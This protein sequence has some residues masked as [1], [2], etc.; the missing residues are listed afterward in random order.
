M[1][2]TQIQPA[3]LVG[4]RSVYDSVFWLAYAANVALMTANALTFR[5]AE[6]VAF[7]G[8][9]EKTAGAI[10][11]VGVVGALLVRLRLGQAIDRFGTRK[12][13]LLSSLLFILGCGML[14]VWRQLSWEMY[15]ARIAFSAGLAGMFTCSIVHIQNQV[16]P[17][18]RTEVIGTLGSSGFVG[19]IAGTLL[20]DA[21]FTALPEGDT[22]FAALFGG[23][24]GLGMV[25]VAIVTLLTH[26]D[27]HDP[28][29]QMP[30][31]LRLLFRYW[32]GCVVLAAL[33]MGVSMSVTTVFLTRFVTYLLSV[34]SNVNG[35]ATFFTAYAASAFV[36][37]L[38]TRQWSHSVGRH[39]M[40]LAGLAG[41]CAG[42]CL[43]PHIT[44]EWHFVIPAIACGWGHAL[45][46]P[47]VISLGA[48]AFP[49][50]YRGIGT[51]LMLGF[52]E[53]GAM[54]S[55]PVLGGIIDYFGVR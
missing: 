22:K 27:S 17:H 49:Q 14:L 25:Y 36:F 55:A 4:G 19:M 39:R 29:Q 33:M 18:R 2:T 50:E 41:Q 53:I 54:M 24:M 31:A 32:P 16:P 10:V 13:W 45:L 34:G 46:F 28:P 35:I 5:F 51:T 52:T 44:S 11:S 38:A 1:R 48:G 21:I 7:L 6:L 3:L 47:A 42:F 26:R 20:G 40:I 15:A 30:P 8:G 37:R 9:T 43:F 12:L 23:A